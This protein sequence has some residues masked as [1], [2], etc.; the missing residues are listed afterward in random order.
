[1]TLRVA[2]RDVELDLGFGPPPVLSSIGRDE[3]EFVAGCDH[4]L[5]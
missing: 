4:S 3:S 2:A 5:L 1:V